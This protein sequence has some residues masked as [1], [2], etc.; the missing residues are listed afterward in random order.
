MRSSTILCKQIEN[1]L[2]RGERRRIIAHSSRMFSSFFRRGVILFTMEGVF[3][4]A[5]GD[6]NRRGRFNLAPLSQNLGRSCH[7]ER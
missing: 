2:A 6:L 3:E 7:G 4:T 5:F 1:Q